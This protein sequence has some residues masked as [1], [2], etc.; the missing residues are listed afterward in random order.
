MSANII[1]DIL[2]APIDFLA[3]TVLDTVEAKEKKVENKEKAEEVKEESY[4]KLSS[5][6]FKKILET[7]ATS[8]NGLVEF[9]EK[10]GTDTAF[11]ALDENGDG[12]IAADEVSK[13]LDNGSLNSKFSVLDLVNAV[14]KKVAKTAAPAPEVKPEA[15]AP[16]Q[17]VTAPSD[18]I[19][20][21]APSGVSS[22]GNY[23]GNT[24][25]NV[26]KAESVQ[27][28]ETQKQKIIQEYDGRIN[29]KNAEMGNAIQQDESISAELKQQYET[30]NQNLANATNALQQTEGKI[31]GLETSLHSNECETTRI[32][33][34]LS[35]I[36]TDTK[37]EEVNSK[38]KARKES[39]SSRLAE[40]KEEKAKLDEQ[41]S[42][43]KDKKTQQ[44]QEK[45]AA[46][47]SLQEIA[48]KIAA[49]ASDETKA[50]IE[51]IKGEIEVLKTEKTQKVGEI[52][53]KIAT[54]KTKEVDR[55]KSMGE[56]AGS[57]G[58]A[59]AA[60]MIELGESNEL[61]DY[62][63]NHFNG[64]YCGV[65]VN[66]LLDY[67]FKKLGFNKTPEGLRYMGR[68]EVKKMTYEQ[69][70]E[71]M[72]TKLRPGMVFEYRYGTDGYHTGMI[73]KVNSDGSWETLEGNTIVNGV[74]GMIGSHTR[75]MNYRNLTAI[76]DPNIALEQ[77]GMY[78]S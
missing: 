69:K 20:P 38:N 57:A 16:E 58:G 61:K 40:L 31:S 50:A 7:A 1:T 54:L 51:R 19:G 2:K 77:A 60:L 33:G 23:S 56:L 21:P 59:L 10:N 49:S 26:P 74:H 15:A 78:L 27:D 48:N 22:G 39:I 63:Y 45:T 46:E 65:F 14:V 43:A 30:A 37:N 25:S 72:R 66:K 6:D 53:N 5:Q 9:I 42:A 3:K 68:V 28:L 44:L 34:E 47:A 24:A 73:A 71:V 35:K 18:F 75:D 8:E 62:F 67:A 29:A 32:E 76:Y 17:P 52:D 64:A 11:K 41:L 13:A 36:K 70:V 4:E 12:T 55:S